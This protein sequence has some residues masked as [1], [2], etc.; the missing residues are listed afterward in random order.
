MLKSL[1]CRASTAAARPYLALL[2]LYK[3]APLPL[4]VGHVL[5]GHLL[6]TQ[7]DLS[8]LAAGG[9]GGVPEGHVLAYKADHALH[10]KFLRAL[11]AKAEHH[12][13]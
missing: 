3:S 10:A 9:G 13:S 1:S 2:L 6:C 7:G 5:T 11:A 8:L 12:D 4:A